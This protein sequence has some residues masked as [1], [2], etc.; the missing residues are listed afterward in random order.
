MATVRCL[1][2]FIGCDSSKS[3]VLGRDFSYGC[4]GDLKPGG[5]GADRLGTPGVTP[6]RGI[7][8]GTMINRYHMMSCDVLYLPFD[9][10]EVLRGF[11]CG[12]TDPV[13]DGDDTN[14]DGDDT[15]RDGGLLGLSVTGNGSIT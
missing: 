5:Q 11:G 2:R 14:S 12:Y 13:N 3:G 6:L 7:G 9:D 10:V 1:L 15:N 8:V 4:F